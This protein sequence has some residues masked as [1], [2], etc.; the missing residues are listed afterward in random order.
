MARFIGGLDLLDLPE[1]VRAIYDR[2]INHILHDAPFSRSRVDRQLVVDSRNAPPVRCRFT[3]SKP[4]GNMNAKRKM[5][6]A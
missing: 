3:A 1:A 6:S 5:S 2:A 4:G